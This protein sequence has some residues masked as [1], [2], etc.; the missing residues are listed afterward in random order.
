MTQKYTALEGEA[1]QAQE[2]QNAVIVNKDKEIAARDKKIARLTKKIE[3]FIN[4]CDDKDDKP[5]WEQV[6]ENE[7]GA[8][9]AVEDTKKTKEVRK[10]EFSESLILMEQI[11]AQEKEDKKV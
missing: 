1:A 2:E 10:D 3:V 9:S 6:D 7:G 4:G 11:L 5:L 8:S